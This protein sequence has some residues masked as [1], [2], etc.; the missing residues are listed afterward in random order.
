MGAVIASDSA[1]GSDC[2]S[3]FSYLEEFALASELT[4]QGIFYVKIKMDA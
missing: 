4:V 2:H 3:D 1:T